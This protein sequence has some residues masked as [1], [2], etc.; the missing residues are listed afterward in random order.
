[1]PHWKDFQMRKLRSRQNKH[2]LKVTPY[3]D[4]MDV[5]SYPD[6]HGLLQYLSFVK[7]GGDVAS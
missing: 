6:T 3:V 4:N 7:N 2:L 5:H 1:M